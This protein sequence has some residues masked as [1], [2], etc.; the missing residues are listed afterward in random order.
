MKIIINQST[1]MDHYCSINPGK[2]KETEK[3][4]ERSLNESRQQKKVHTVSPEHNY[5]RAMLRGCWLYRFVWLAAAGH[6][7][8]GQSDK[9]VVVRGSNLFSKLQSLPAHCTVG[10]WAL[11]EWDD[12]TATWRTSPLRWLVD[13][14]EE[15]HSFRPVGLFFFHFHVLYVCLSRL[16]GGVMSPPQA[17]PGPSLIAEIM[18]GTKGR[19]HFPCFSRYTFGFGFQTG[20]PESPLFNPFRAENLFKDFIS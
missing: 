9:L 20:R 12:V 16:W 11:P 1:H 2:V 7:H 10:I 17:S 15:R 5:P 18:Q 19:D 8:C 3:E 13:K 14:T 6:S 4:R